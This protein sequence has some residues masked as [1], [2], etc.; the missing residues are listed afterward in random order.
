MFYKGFF[1]VYS[2]GMLNLTN[3]AELARSAT[4]N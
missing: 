2:D 4:A 3:N 1:N